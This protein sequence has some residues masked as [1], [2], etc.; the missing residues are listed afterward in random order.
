MSQLYQVDGKWMTIDQIH[1]LR[2]KKEEVVVEPIEEVV[3]EEE[4][5]VL[6]VEEVLSVDEE[7]PKE[8]M[9]DG[10]LD[11]SELEKCTI[12]ELRD[13]AKEHGITVKGQPSKKTLINLLIQK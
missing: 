2:S 6:T 4:K 8:I 5:E 9:F 3:S 10:V 7:L 12:M 11:V 1:A 13:I